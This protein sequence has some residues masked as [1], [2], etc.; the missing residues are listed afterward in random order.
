ML[1]PTILINLKLCTGCWTCSLACKTGNQLADNE[2]WQYVRTLGNGSGIDRPAGTWPHLHMS[3]LPV[4]TKDCT[5][6]GGRTKTGLAPYCVYNCP[7]NAMCFGDLE[8]AGSEVSRKLEQLKSRGYRI[9]RL[10]EWE[11][12]RS[13]VVYADRS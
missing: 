2:W 4:H 13:E 12:S 1:K 10:P 11:H 3:W 5:L 6:C 8:D 7:N 9:F